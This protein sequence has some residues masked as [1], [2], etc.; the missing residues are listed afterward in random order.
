[1]SDDDLWSVRDLI[2]DLRDEGAAG[3][4]EAELVPWLEQR[5]AVR[6]RLRELG[7]PDAH[8]WRGESAS[9][10]LYPVGRLVDLLIAPHQPVSD[11]PTLL[12]W[13]TGRPWWTGPLPAPTAWGV[14]R[15]AVGAV[16]IAEDRFHPFFHEIVAVSMWKDPAEPPHV[17]AEHWPGVLVGGLL[18][19]RA[20]VTVRAGAN[21]LDPA[22]AARSCLYFAWWRRNRVV[23]DMSHGWGSNSQWST[24]FRRD[25]VVGDELHYNVGGARAGGS[26]ADDDTDVSTDERRDLL[27]FRHSTRRDLGSERWPYYDALVEPRPPQRLC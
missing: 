10:A 8:R 5:P 18:L 21:V 14:F 17:V 12:A 4:G 19:A 16:T 3:W 27:R 24:D 2:L 25:Y 1:V 15:A 23:R 11:D 13:T 6:Q 26:P 7:G 20:G 9:M 22:I